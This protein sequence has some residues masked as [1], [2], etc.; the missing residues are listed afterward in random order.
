MLK[1]IIVDDE[2]DAVNFI[3]S[4]IDEYCKEIE[5]VGKAHSAREGIREIVDCHRGCPGN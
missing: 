5:V 3:Q 1:A 4:L 2:L